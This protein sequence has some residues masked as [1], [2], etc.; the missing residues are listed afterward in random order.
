M[1][2]NLNGYLLDPASYYEV[3]VVEGFRFHT[4]AFIFSRDEDLSKPSLAT[5]FYS[6]IEYGFIDDMSMLLDLYLPKDNLK[7]F[8]LIVWIHGGGWVVHSKEYYVPVHMVD[9]GFAIASINYRLSHE[10]A[11]PSQLEECK[12]A[13]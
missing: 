2:N 13:I 12:A 3:A 11:F 1:C 8:P 9:N 6:N 4:E 10:A 5:N 7:S